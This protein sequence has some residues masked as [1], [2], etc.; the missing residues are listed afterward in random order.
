M[1][2]FTPEDF[3]KMMEVTDTTRLTPFVEVK[4]P[5]YRAVASNFF[6]LPIGLL[7]ALKEANMEQDGSDILIL[8]DAA[9]IAFTEED[10]E[11][12]QDL[13]ISDFFHVV[14]TWLTASA[15]P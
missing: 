12:M 2:E 11:R 1:S 15:T 6:H 7:V 9:E 13:S 5:N 8:F 14:R 4:T 3:D 10:F